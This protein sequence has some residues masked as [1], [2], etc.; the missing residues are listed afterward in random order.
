MKQVLLT[1]FFKTIETVKEKNDMKEICVDKSSQDCIINISDISS[2]LSSSKLN[3]WYC[4]E[5]GENM[6]D[7]PRQLCGKSYCYNNC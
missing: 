1:N 5:C 4:L 2:H 7:N 3:N 6:G